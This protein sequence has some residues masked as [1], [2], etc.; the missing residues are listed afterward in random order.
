MSSSLAPSEQRYV[1]A[2]GH[3]CS[4]EWQ[5]A[6]ESRS[7]VIARRSTIG[8]GWR[9]DVCI[10]DPTVSRAHAELDP[11]DDGVWVRDLKSK[12]GT[13]VGDERIEGR[14][15][16]Y[17]ATIRIGYIDLHLR[18]ASVEPGAVSTPWPFECFGPLVGRSPAMRDLF[19]ALSHL[20]PRECTILISGET[21]TGKELVAQ[22]LHQGSR[23]ASGP[24]T[25]V[26]CGALSD[27]L[28]EAEL[29]G[30]TKGAFTGAE[31][32]HVGA[33][34]AADDGTVFLD[35]IGELPMS[36]Q[37][38]LLRALE[39]STI[40][41]IGESKHRKVNVR[42]IAAT[43]RDLRAMVDR[44]QFREDLYY[45]LAVVPVQVPPLRERPEDIDL[46]LEHFAPGVG[47]WL[48]PGV[49]G[50]L[51]S[52][53]W[54]GNVRELRN[55]AT[56]VQATKDFRTVLQTV[57][58]TNEIVPKTSRPPERLTVSPGAAEPAPAPTQ[59]PLVPALRSFSPLSPLPVAAD[60]SSVQALREF[61]EAW[62]NYG[63]RA[64]L[65]ALRE[66]HGDDVATA[67]KEA[68]VDRT[69]LY[70]LLRKHSM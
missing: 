13:F 32:A 14:L 48:T 20:A 42:F 41:R 69:H 38:K 61:R 7:Q 24:L 11:R 62:M 26:D 29:F 22:A 51:R 58:E 1:T 63:E 15:V 36:L 25:V 37:P 18:S 40:R 34:E 44:G 23:R 64:F 2:P 52:R 33:I 9:C 4:V 31:R 59:A 47:E 66:R 28:I 49:L 27:T 39:S 50:K 56:R 55:F 6:I 45:R 16:P 12:N 30:Y 68:G 43:H 57:A 46:L 10:I 8:S 60:P 17:G 67:A 5:D 70:R 35:E 21:G 19:T 3:A 54:R 65:R 53:K